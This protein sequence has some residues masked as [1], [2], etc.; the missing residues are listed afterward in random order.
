VNLRYRFAFLLA[1]AGLGLCGYAG[2]Q[3]RALPDYSEQD[4]QAST[5]LNLAF[6]LARRGDRDPLP[7]DRLDELRKQERAEIEQA[8]RADRS[9]VERYFAAGLALVVVA[10]G[11]FVAGRLT[12]QAAGKG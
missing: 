11:Q 5:E 1:A 6:D 12:A 3:W 7:V 4:L 10:L 8:I 2:L 9:R